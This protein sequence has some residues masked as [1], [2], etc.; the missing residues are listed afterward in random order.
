MKM[1]RLGLIAR[2]AL[3]VVCVEVAAFGVLGWFYIDRFSRAADEQ[4]RSRLQLVG[5][6][7]ANDELAV[8]AIS[9]PSF[10]SELV[11]APYLNG[12]VV[13]GNGRIIVA[14][15]PAYLG[16]LA[17]DVGGFD[18]RWTAAAAE[19]FIPGEDILTAVMHI[20]GAEGGASMYI[21][22]ITTST[23]Q[24]NARKRSIAMWGQLGSLLFILLSTA[25]I[26]IIAQRL[27]TRRVNTSLKV[28]KEVE[29]GNI[30][31]R[32]PVSS[33]DE[34]GRLQH[35]INSMTE[36]VGALL[37]QH[38]RNEEEIR[39]T[40]RILD[41]IVENIPN[42]IFL[43]RASDLRYVLFNKAGEK[44]LDID[45]QEL[46][47]KNDYDLF[48]R[49]QA[50]LFTA[51]DRLA[52][53]SPAVLDIPEETVATRG[54]AQRIL[55]TQKLALHNSNGEAEYLLGI[56][57]DISERKKAE[58]RIREL[59]FF[60]QLTG[61]PNRTLLQDRLKQAMSSGNRNGSF[62]AVLL[63]DLDNFKTLNDTLGHDIGDMLLKQVAQR[64]TLIMRECDTVA[65]LGGDEFV[66]VLAGL[67]TRAREAAN[68]VEAITLKILASLKQ[69][70]PL[71]NMSHQT[72]A[73]IGVTLFQGDHASIDDLIKQADLAMYESKA[74]G[75]NALRFFDPSLEA[76]V[77][78]RAAL[79]DD[80][81]RAIVEKQFLLHYQAQISS[82]QM[83]ADQTTGS[84]VLLRWQHPQRGLVAP[85][86]F[87]PLAEETGLIV[88]L[89]H[90]V[91]QTAC[92][93]LAAWAARPEFAHLT[94]AV[95]VSAHQFRQADFV[96][97]VLE[98]LK[99]TGANPQK[100][101]L[102]LTESLLVS[103]VDE[104]IEKMFALK[105]AGVSFSLDDF[106]TGYSSLSYLK[107]LPLDQLK[108]DQSFVHDVM[109]N[110]SDASI[111]RSIIVLASNLGLGVIAEGVETKTQREF[112]AN[113]GCHA[114]Q[115]YY[116]SRPL[117][118]EDFE[119]FVRGVV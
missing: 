65:R 86:E 4:M 72:T 11:G 115:G 9:R 51:H 44:L 3:L 104:V 8:S 1:I 75:R 42:T 63:I 88:P 57:E 12:M 118:L 30:D 82:E 43:K 67:D 32:I 99:N 40:S 17:S 71:G 7:I 98:V 108:I 85:D 110:A 58:E 10:M 79:E 55:H 68:A 16:R 45:R 49:E 111:A 106:G 83:G 25:A 28:L 69:P 80:L 81:R 48:S 95:N 117:P 64:L 87:I 35:G 20:R 26:V 113:L 21:T 103:S 100:L 54:G 112:L 60:D 109:D 56:S 78:A 59:A 37:Q 74:G 27:I 47:G 46:L 70:Y 33:N 101:K 107:R 19:E 119:R 15:N 94:V 24:L 62:G 23:A 66:V 52:L 13:G 29:D 31:A 92:K 97:L 61:L 5:R 89:G 73:S 96:E 38:R 53:S 91:L 6:M 14:T 102:E 2:I 22:V 36:K 50:D 77:K 39:T 116:F 76:A 84:E 93:Q 18:A 114:Y 90:W 105:A 34:L 41:T